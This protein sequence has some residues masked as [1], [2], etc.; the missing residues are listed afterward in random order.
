MKE[1]PETAGI[2]IVIVSGAVDQKEIDS[3][4]LDGADGF[5]PKP[6]DPSSFLQ[7]ITNLLAA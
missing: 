1:N 2:Q 3:L 4:L 5:I 6:F 7:K